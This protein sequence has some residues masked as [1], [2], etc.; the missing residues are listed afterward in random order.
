MIELPNAQSH[1]CVADWIEIHLATSADA[2]SKAELSS[3]IEGLTGE[4]ASDAFLSSVWNELYFRQRRYT[5][6]SFDVSERRIN[7]V[8]GG[9][10]RIEYI[11][12]LILSLFGAP[13]GQIPGKLFERLSAL[14]LQEYMRGEVFIFGWPILDGTETAIGKRVRDLSTKI[15]ERFAEEPSARYLDRGVDIIA[16]KPFAEGRSSQCIILAQCAAGKHWGNKTRDLPKE[17]WEQYIHWACD[18]VTAFFVPCIIPDD[19]WHDISREAGILFD[20]IRIINLL[21]NGITDQEL[22]LESK[23]WTEE[24]LV[25][26]S[27]D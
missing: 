20:R 27:V 4:E 11:V 21:P 10:Q 15:G 14:A 13:D 7:R 22:S 9:H 18:F 2:I 19:L 6:P 23:A 24:Q 8:N 17:S 25:E 5:K 16:W 3:I 1:A 26:Y 12:C